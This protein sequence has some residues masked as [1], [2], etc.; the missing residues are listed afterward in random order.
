MDECNAEKRTPDGITSRKCFTCIFNYGSC[1]FSKVSEGNITSPKER[2]KSPIFHQAPQSIH[3]YVTHNQPANLTW[4]ATNVCKIQIK[5]NRKKFQDGDTR[6]CG[7]TRTRMKTKIVTVADFPKKTRIITCQCKVWGKIAVR[8]EKII[9]E[10]AFLRRNFG[11]VRDQLH[12]V[13]SPNMSV[14]LQCKPPV[15][16]PRPNIT[17]YKNGKALL[18]RGRRVRLR[19]RNGL[20]IKR[21]QMRDSGEYQCVAKNMA[22]RREGP[23][24]T[25]DVRENISTAVCTENQWPCTSSPDCNSGSNT[26]LDCEPPIL[27]VGTQDGLYSIDLLNTSTQWRRIE[28]KNI[29]SLDFG[30]DPNL[31]YWSDKKGINRF[32][33]A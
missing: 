7:K 9:L 18:L 5:C 19:S 14:V 4:V 26:S 6:V 8:T 21:V 24:M 31:I 28:A 25:L 23:V 27:L 2:D 3:Y 12:N 16:S 15:G 29:V 32:F 33:H 10:K 11:T 1:R 30:L 17:W 13:V 20:I 22:A